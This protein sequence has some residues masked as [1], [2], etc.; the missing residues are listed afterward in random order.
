V[1]RDGERLIP[2][3]W[4]EASWQPRTASRFTGD[5]YGYGWFMRRVAGEDVYYGWGYGGQMIYVVP[6]QELVAAMTS[7]DNSPAGR[8]GHRGDLHALLG[9]VVA[10]VKDLRAEAFVE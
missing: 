2:I 7:D 4:I 9:R 10:A 1:S 6:G 3:E 5:G 8:S